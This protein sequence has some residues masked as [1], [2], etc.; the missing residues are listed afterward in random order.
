MQTKPGVPTI[1]DVA[2]LA[3]VSKRTVSRVIN[4]SDQVSVDTRRRVLK[5]IETLKFTPNSLA[6]GLAA[7]RSFLLGL[8]YDVPTLFINDVQKGLLSVCADKGYELVVHPC[9]IDSPRLV[10]DVRSFVARSKVEGVIMLPPVSDVPE[11]GEAVD[12]LGI[13]HVRFSSQHAT[14][15]WRLV[16]TNYGPAVDELTDHLVGLGHRAIG[17]ISGPRDN[18]PSQMRQQAFVA[19][20]A[21]HGLTLREEFIAEGA[22]TYESGL[23]AARSL[24]SKSTRPT[25]IFAANDEMALSVMN[26]AHDLGLS[27]PDD[28]SVV[29]FDG[30]P[31]AG[32]VI[33]SL[34]TIHRPS[35]E[36]ASLAARKLLTLINEGRQAASDLESIISPRFVPRASTGRAPA[37]H[38]R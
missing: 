29:G 33:P 18:I 5:V 12:S 9:E 6:R 15:A 31:F 4:E 37:E 16:I 32:F 27:I 21:R 35:A 3:G 24:L 7:R 17:F 25:A 20:L 14:D 13:P 26:V 28:L 38:T 30:T 34:S 8:I 23:S 36:M 19:A 11:L 2:A 1:N 22:F 10:D